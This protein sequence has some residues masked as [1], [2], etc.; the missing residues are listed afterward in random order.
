MEIYFT[1][2]FINLSIALANKRLVNINSRGMIEMPEKYTKAEIVR[3]ILE[4]DM[5]NASENE[6]IIHMLLNKTV[7]R[8]TNNSQNEALSFGDKIADRIAEVAGS[9]S[10]ILSFCTLLILWIVLNSVLLLN[11][12]D[13]YPFILLNLLLSCVAAIQAPIIM[14]SQNRQEL[15]DRIQSENDYRVNLKSELIVE[16]LHQKLDIL[17]NNQEQ[18]INRL[19][20]IENTIDKN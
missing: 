3:F 5:N 15:K 9:W 12:F 18:L 14:M 19:D 8:N 20:R 17:I 13:P 6:E 10:F 11:K 16:D 7:S 2:Q 1:L 4:D